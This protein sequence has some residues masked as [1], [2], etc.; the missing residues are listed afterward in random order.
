MRIFFQ[1]HL[2]GVNEMVVYIE[3]KYKTWIRRKYNKIKKC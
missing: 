1:C 2:D 3:N